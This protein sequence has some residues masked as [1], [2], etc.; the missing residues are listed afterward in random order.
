MRVVFPTISKLYTLS[1]AVAFLANSGCSPFAGFGSNASS[2]S[3][4]FTPGLTSSLPQSWTFTPAN[5][6]GYLLGTNTDISS[7]ILELTSAAQVDSSFSSSTTNGTIYGTLSDGTSTGLKLGNDGICNSLTTNCSKFDSSW[8]PH[9]SSIVGLW[10]FDEIAGTSGVG[11][12]IDSSGSGNNATPSSVT[13]GGAG[14]IGNAASFNGT[15]SYMLS[16][17]NSSGVNGMNAM[18]ISVWMNSST[19]AGVQEFARQDVTF[20]FRIADAAGHVVFYVADTGSTWYNSTN[21]TVTVLDGKWHFITG[22]YD[23]AA[24]KIY[25]DGVLSASNPVG[26]IT[27]GAGTNPINFGRFQGSTEYYGGLM[28]ELGIWKVALSASDIATIY[29]RQS[30][31]YSGAYTSKVID[32]YQAGSSWTSLSWIPTLPFLK[33]L[34]DSGASESTTSYTSLTNS[35]LMNGIVGLW[36]LDEPAG[37]VAANSI[38]DNSGQGNHGT[39]SSVTFG[40]PGAFGTAGLFT[41]TTTS[42]VATTAS[43]AVGSAVTLSAWVNTLGAQAAYQNII[44][45]AANCASFQMY[46][47]SAT[48]NLSFYSIGS[49]LITPAV[50]VPANQWSHVSIVVSGGNA[51][52]YVNGVLQSTQAATINDLSTGVI[53][54][55]G[56]AAGNKNFNGSVDEVAIWN[57]AL[58]AIE[59][60]Q[61]YQRGA[62]RIKYRV[63]SCS[64]STCTT[65]SPIF[66]GP[67]GTVNTYFS[68]V[69]NMSTQAAT[70]SGT[71]QT[72]LPSMS[73][74]NYTSPVATNRYFQYQMVLESDTAT[75]TLMPEVKSVTV[76]PNHYDSSSPTVI[77]KSG[78]TY[79]NLSGFTETLGA[80]GCTSGVTYNLGV[81]TSYSSATWYYWNGSAWASAGGTTVT[82]SSAATINSHASSFAATAGTGQVYFKA[83]LNSSGSSK[84]ELSNLLLS[85]Q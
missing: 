47:N 39:P 44:C 45:K 25:V 24:A 68:E 55:G 28:D 58:S 61:V 7:N 22:V 33:A 40:V 15:T 75:T 50:P 57:R 14:Q 35:S 1:I 26:A 48:T 23:G 70:P 34:P 74:Q 29:A 60:Q 38:I 27:I 77:S 10:H 83:F 36:H 63:R 66:Q 43:V 78:V 80:G 54:I 30:P 56:Y 59:I 69:F 3:A 12:V 6:S 20:A 19:S 73:L 32:A 18:S 62:S 84:C 13:F 64:D 42:Q 5:S 52:F 21:S 81:G 49:G 31:K 79:R 67:D 11:S 71:V 85:G 65:G 82:S 37:T 72:G 46:L 53:D 51:L 41:Q 4:N 2:K 8:T 17:S 9:W 16:T 76:G